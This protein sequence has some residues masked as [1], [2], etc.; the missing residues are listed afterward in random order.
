[1]AKSG[2]LFK[3]ILGIGGAVAAVVLSNKQNR[4]NLKQEY[5]KYKENPDDYKK[6]AQQKAAQV[7]ETAAQ[8]FNK[9]K[10]DPKAY[11][12]E[13]KEDPKAFFSNKKE[14]LLN[15]EQRDDELE[16][17]EAQFDGEGGGNPSNNLHVETK[18]TLKNK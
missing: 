4:E 8:E 10:E 17:R 6:R 12:N 15:G 5:Q 14:Q 16:K 7:G 2:K 3:A 13:A 11:L 9:V 18:E 1:M